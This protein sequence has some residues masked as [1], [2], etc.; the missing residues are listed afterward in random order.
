MREHMKNETFEILVK[1]VNKSATLSGRQKKDVENHLT[2]INRQLEPLSIEN[3]EATQSIVN[4]L[5]CVIF[6]STRHKRT[7]ILATA[8]RKGMLLSFRPYEE[9]HPELVATA[10]SLGDILSGLG[11]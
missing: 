3:P 1:S 9:T 7:D 2:V 8:A 10:Y 11:I 4:F 6:E 5:S